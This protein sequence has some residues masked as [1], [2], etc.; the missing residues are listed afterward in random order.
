MENLSK[1]LPSALSF[2]QKLLSGDRSTIMGAIEP[3]VQ[4]VTS[5]YEAGRVAENEFAPRGGG[6][7]AA[8]VESQWKETSDI[9]TLV[10]QGQQEGAQGMLSIDSLLADLTTG[11]AAGASSTLSSEAS[12]LQA[13]HDSSQAASQSLGVG[14]GSMIALLTA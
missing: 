3:A 6:R 13:Q 5:Q 7:T 11:S 4:S 12:S 9:S 8:D 14:V 2:F 1:S 10:S